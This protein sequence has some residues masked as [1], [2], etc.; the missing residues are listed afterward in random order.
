[1]TRPATSAALGGALAAALAGPG[2]GQTG[3][4]ARLRRAPADVVWIGAGEFV[5]GAT[6]ADVRL[7]GVLCA[8]EPLAGSSALTALCALRRRELAFGPACDEAAFADERGGH[9]VWLRAFG[10]DRT[11]VTVGAYDRCVS[12]GACRS[13]PI[14]PGTP[15][16]GG[17]SQPM[18]RVSW[19]M[20]DAYCRWAH[21]RLP[22]EAEWERAARGRDGRPF[23][24]GR[25][26]D[27][28]R[29]NHGIIAGDCLDDADG[30]SLTAPV[31]SYPDGASPDGA[32]DMAGNVWEWVADLWSEESRYPD[33][34]TRL[35]DPRG[36]SHGAQHVIRGGS[37]RSPA[38]ALRTTYRA[39]AAT[40]LQSDEIGFRCAYDRETR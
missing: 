9:T 14:A 28:R 2:T 25:Q 34:G 5:M 26:Y 19:D 17:S 11:E 36:A 27:P 18:V 10:I 39:A 29:A 32:L 35:V 38:F 24:W 40:G 22:T 33:P 21:G 7:A 8:R 13:A 20:A 6:D 30:E 15:Q 23:P 31:G 4:T 3:E 16:F 1:M 37:Y 12:A